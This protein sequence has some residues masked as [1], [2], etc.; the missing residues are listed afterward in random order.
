MEL[1]FLKDNF[2]SLIKLQHVLCD[3][4]TPIC[5]DAGCSWLII[6]LYKMFSPEV[7]TAQLEKGAAVLTLF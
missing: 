7:G 2:S 5:I 1:G 6:C 4:L 3:L